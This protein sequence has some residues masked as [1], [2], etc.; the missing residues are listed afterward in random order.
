MDPHKQQLLETQN[1]TLERIA[2][3]LERIS[4]APV[5]EADD[6]VAP[7]ARKGDPGY[8]ARGAKI[9]QL[10]RK[11]KHWRQEDLANETGLQVGTISRIETGFHQPQLGTISKIAKALGVDI[12]DIV[13]WHDD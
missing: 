2:D 9:R 4:G 5:L 13:D 11:K 10:R 8:T 6:L 7:E 3:A 1:D 12:D